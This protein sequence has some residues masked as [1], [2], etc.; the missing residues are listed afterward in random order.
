MEKESG[1]LLPM[2]NERWEKIL[3]SADTRTQTVNYEKS[4]Y[5]AVVDSLPSVNTKCDG[6]HRRCYKAFTAIQSSSTNPQ[7]CSSKDLRS[8]TPSQVTD[9]TNEKSRLGIFEDKCLYCNKQKKTLVD[10]RK[11]GLGSVLSKEAENKIREAAKLLKDTSVLIK[12]SGIDMIAKEVKFH[13]SCRSKALA[14]ATRVKSAGE[15]SI[16]KKP[17]ERQSAMQIL[18]YVKIHVILGS[19]PEKLKSIYE[20][21][22]LLC[23]VEEESSISS[24][25]YLGTLLKRLFTRVTI[26]L[27]WCKE[28][29]NYNSQ[30]SS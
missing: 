9:S 25:Q 30:P 18:D 10:G 17:I 29:R 20:R 5:K 16:G 12:V 27:F 24:C 1:S 28:A 26:I 6:Y 11:E 4:K 19:R 15:T 22:C 2:T 23:E 3:K 8:K 13:H 7:P 21:Y 14:T